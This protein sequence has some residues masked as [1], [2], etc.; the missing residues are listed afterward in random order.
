MDGAGQQA[1]RSCAM[2]DNSYA[3]LETLDLRYPVWDRCF[4]V[5][6]L[7]LVLDQACRAC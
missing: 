3:D 1:A 7:V 6:P 4:T 2:S 5:A